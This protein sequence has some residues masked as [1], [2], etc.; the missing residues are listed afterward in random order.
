MLNKAFL[1][2]AENSGIDCKQGVNPLM[3]DTPHMVAFGL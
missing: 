2:Q 1:L 3:S